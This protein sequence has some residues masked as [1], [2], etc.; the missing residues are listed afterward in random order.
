LVSWGLLAAAV[1]WGLALRSRI[2]GSRP[3]PAWLLDLHRYL[4]GVAVLF[5]GVHVGAVLLDGYVHFDL[6]QVLVP[7]TSTW[8]PGAVA[9]G[10]VALY[11]LLAVELTSLARAHLSR[12][13]WRRVHYLSFPL[14]VVATIH[15]LSAGTDRGTSVFQIGVW[16][17]CALVAVLTALRARPAAPAGPAATA[18]R[19]APRSGAG[20]V[21][22]APPRPADGAPV[23]AGRPV[24][25]APAARRTPVGSRAVVPPPRRR[26][27]A[28][29]S[30]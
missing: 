1:L 6:V 29:P 9:W 21:G 14:F 19:P 30:A 4:A 28:Q 3:R 20:P 2:L 27:P 7:F 17:V 24:P 23:T 18:R 8:H 16:S 12:K 11:L 26:V 22:A 10:I 25:A 15:A 13:L 5:V